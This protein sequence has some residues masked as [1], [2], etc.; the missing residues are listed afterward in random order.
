M[1]NKLG[2]ISVSVAGIFILLTGCNTMSRLYKENDYEK[3]YQAAMNFYEKG[4]KTDKKRNFARSIQL[5]DDVAL[6]YLG[7]AR[8]DSIA[9]Y[10]ASANFKTGDFMSSGMLFDNFR[11][12]YP[13]S[14]FI[15]QAEYMYVISYYNMAPEPTRDQ[16]YT[17]M[18][19]MALDEYLERYPNTI[20]REYCLLCRDELKMLLYEHEYLCAKTYYKIRN[21]KSAIVAT[22][23][24]A[25]KYLDSPFREDLLYMTL[26]SSYEY[27]RNSVASKQKDRYLDMVDYYY[28]FISE[29]PESKNR[30]SADK[31]LKAARAFL[32]KEQKFE[33]VI[34]DVPDMN[35]PII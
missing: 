27:A 1:K 14:R 16:S 21:Y 28:T 24:A 26:E 11:R 12:K 8:E 30:A 32:D 7:T 5:F 17:A 18:A 10:T 31:M 33:K 34:E 13:R 6:Y 22:R 4:N 35:L 3:M 23:N 19:I 9:F 15:E 29:F 20:Y 2:I 25:A